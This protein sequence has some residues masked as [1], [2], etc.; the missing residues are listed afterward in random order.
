MRGLGK[1]WLPAAPL[2]SWAVLLVAKPR[3]WEPTARMTGG[4]G[5]PFAAIYT[6]ASLFGAALL[7]V[8][9]LHRNKLVA[10]PSGILGACIVLVYFV[11][12]L[13]L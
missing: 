6:I 1:L 9:V 13:R 5:P 10:Y 2:L 4:S 8:A 3:L 11:V 7:V 12:A